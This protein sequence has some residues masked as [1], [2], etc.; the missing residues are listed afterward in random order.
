MVREERQAGFTYYSLAPQNG[1]SHWPLIQLARQERDENGDR[2]RL[3]D[4]LRQREDRQAL[5]EKLLEPGQSWFLWAT[6]MASL[7]PPLE[8]ADF[9]C[10]SGLLSVAIARW[11]K[12]VIAIDQNLAALEQAR[13]RAAREAV[14]NIRFVQEDL[15]QLSLPAGATDL[16][17]ISQSLHHV[18]QPEAVLQEAAR[19]LKVAGRIIVLELMPHQETWVSDQLGHQHL[20]FDPKWLEGSLKEVGFL[21][22]SRQLPERQGASPFRVFLLSGEKKQ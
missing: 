4:L 15:H 21:K 13:Q 17:V 11:A 18:R 14:E 20:G 19:I 6:A 2:A 7:L 8:V 5:N 3:T 10:G 22:V 16:V 12:K 9:G 1:G